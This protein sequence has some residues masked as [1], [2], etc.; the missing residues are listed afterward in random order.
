M[1]QTARTRPTAL[2]TGASSGLGASYAR[3]LAEQ[4]Y[5]LVLVARRRDRLES[6]AADLRAA[7]D[8]RSEV[9]VADLVEPDGRAAVQAR[10]GRGDIEL[11][12]N[13]AGFPGYRPFVDLDPDVADDLIRLHVRVP[14]LLTRAALPHMLRRRSGAV[15]NVASLLA[16]SG[17]I[18]ANPMPYRAVYAGAKAYLLTFTQTLAGELK[19]SGVR[20][21]LLLPGVVA[22]EFHDQLNIDRGRLASM[23]MQA[24]EVV[25]ASL[26]A[27]DRGELLCVP[28]LEDPSLLEELGKAQRAVMEAGNRPQ[29]AGRYKTAAPSR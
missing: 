2:I 9:L 10:A 27:L 16:L 22:T 28:G 25:A 29:L 14:T 21:Q 5:D 17:T 13:N 12:I 26:A 6:L 1:S 23:A 15:I 7:S 20:L 19:D 11:L 24:D 18:P 8:V 4:G 3:R